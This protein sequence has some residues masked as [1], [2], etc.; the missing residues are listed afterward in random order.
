MRNILFVFCLTALAAPAAK[1]DRIALPND[2]PATS[3]TQTSAGQPL[4]TAILRDE[5]FTD[6]LFP[7]AVEYPESPEESAD[8][9]VAPP[10]A[11][12][13]FLPVPKVIL[14]RLEPIT[15]S[16]APEPSALLLISLGILT[17][18][19]LQLRARRECRR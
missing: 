15:E 3:Y 5:F 13:T 2:L 7:F 6:L 11:R 14:P 16:P 4:D 17:L 1:A 8:S 19:V 10:G 18:L 9:L 12:P